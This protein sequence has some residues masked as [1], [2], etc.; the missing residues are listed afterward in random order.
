MT[1]PDFF[2]INAI[3]SDSHL[4]FI[5]WTVVNNGAWDYAADTRGYT[6]GGM[7]EYDDKQ[8]SIRFGLFAM[9]IVANGIDMD[10][11]FTGCGKRSQVSLLRNSASHVVYAAGIA[12]FRIGL[13]CAVTS[14]CF[15]V[16]DRPTQELVRST[17]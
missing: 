6:V 14:R 13:P 4:Q 2:D 15:S 3:G 10:W 17:W 1:L 8:W 12:N 16:G 9:P 5:N 11:A 7:A